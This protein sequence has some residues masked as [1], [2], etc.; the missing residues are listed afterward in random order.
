MLHDAFELPSGHV[1]ECDVCIV[2]AGAAGMALAH[3]LI[4]EGLKVVVLESGGARL[5]KST[6][7]LHKGAIA[8]PEKHAPLHEYRLRQLG[9]TTNVWGGRCAPYDAIDFEERPHVPHSRWPFG[10]Q[11]LDPYYERAHTYCDLGDYVYDAERAHL[12]GPSSMIPGFVS[13]QVTTEKIWR[14]SSPTNFRKKY[15]PTLERSPDVH[16][17]THANCLNI[18]TTPDGRGV[19]HLVVASLK[20]NSFKVHAKQYVLAAGALEVTRL[21]LL[22]RDVHTEGIGNHA[23]LLGKFYMSHLSGDMG[24]IQF[25]VP[26][27]KITWDY[28][29]T[30]GGVYCR[31]TFSLTE[32][33]QREHGLLNFRAMLA[34]PLEAD[35]SHGNSVLSTKYFL[36]WLVSKRSQAGYQRAISGENLYRHLGQHLGNIA[37]D[38]L[39]L[40]RFSSEWVSKR[41]IPERKLPSVTLGSNSSTYWL[42]YDAEQSP[43]P[44]SRVGLGRKKDAF[45]L[46]RLDVDYHY[47]AA[48]EESVVRSVEL[49]AEAVERTG[50]GR[51]EVDRETLREQAQHWRVASHHIG[52]T[53]MA[54]EASEGVV[55]ADGRVFG[56]DN[57]YVA[58]SSVLPTS[59]Y[60]NPTL[61][62]VA[63]AIR[64]A[65][66]LKRLYRQGARRD[67]ATTARLV[68]D[69]TPALDSTRASTK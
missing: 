12:D 55:D 27:E 15:T 57:L 26:N 34:N 44:Q 2:G 18:A 5:E 50:V 24:P 49:I 45:G 3:E 46:N 69:N 37:R 10:K 58:S 28:E 33:A 31:R 25:A 17:Y 43:N 16:V 61:T 54:K 41:I 13:S 30:P 21:L 22:S 35:P 6:Q 62:I 32:E 67:Q 29:K 9:G 65:E 38:P 56:V 11:E 66:H 53:R 40:L 60:A 20:K 68:I 36:K 39:G 51:M 19:D 63:I 14:W 1:V 7:D 8:D 4:G 48:D 52:T 64:V 42:H 47:V 23:G 59:S